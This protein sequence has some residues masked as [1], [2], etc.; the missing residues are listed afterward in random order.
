MRSKIAVVG[1]GFAGL[2]VCHH[3]LQSCE[4][5]VFDPLGIGGGASGISTGLLHPFPA[6]LS[7]RSWLAGEGMDASRELL[8]V[9]EKALGKAAIVD[10]QPLQAGDVPITFADISKA[11]TKLGYQPRV[12]IDQ[13]IPLFVDWFNRNTV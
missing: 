4:V 3:L 2:S 13:G 11:R 8:L 6:R 1:A 10:R 9:A 12:K 7:I 5:T